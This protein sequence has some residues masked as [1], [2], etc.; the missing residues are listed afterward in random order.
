MPEPS[1]ELL[2][3]MVQKALDSQREAR[4]DVREI[5]ARLGRLETDIAQLHVFL[6]ATG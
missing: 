1:P 3:Q 2:M 5:K 6:A 4:K